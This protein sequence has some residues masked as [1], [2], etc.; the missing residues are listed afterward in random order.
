MF[1]CG[2]PTT[3]Q[4][5]A[6]AAGCGMVAGRRATSALVPASAGDGCRYKAISPSQTSEPVHNA[7]VFTIDAASGVIRFGDGIRGR[8]PPDGSTLRVDYDFGAGAQGNVG[9]G[10]VDAAP[11]LAGIKVTNPLPT[12]GAAEAETVAEAERQARRYLQHRD[13]LVSVA[14]FETIVRRTP[15]VDVGRVDVLPA[16][17]PQITPPVETPGAVTVLVLP[18]TDSRH[19]AAPEPDR[20]FLNT[21]C[22]YLTP[23]RLVTTELYL[24]GPTYIDLWIS[25]GVEVEA[26]RSVAVTYDAVRSALIRF[27]APL[28]PSGDASDGWPL[29]KAVH[30]LELAAVASRVPGVRLVNKVLVAAGTGGPEDVI[31]IKGLELPRVRA[32]AV[33]ADA[34]DLD[35]VRGQQPPPSPP[36]A[37]PVPVVPEEC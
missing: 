18:R 31:T 1:R 8:R 16:Y 20:L 19:P 23:R 14:D 6:T 17:N 33:G 3:S 4:E 28:N 5:R 13:R 32:V 9:A 11:S 34:A 24:R 37:V 27:L 36:A 7:S 30:R 21:I 15:G 29:D 25:I 12:W 10:A 22:R 35:Q 2:P 26:G